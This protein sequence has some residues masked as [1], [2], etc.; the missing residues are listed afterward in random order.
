ML[1]SARIYQKLHINVFFCIQTIKSQMHKW[2]GFVTFILGSCCVKCWLLHSNASFHQW[3]LTCLYVT[4]YP[5][6]VCKDFLPLFELS[7]TQLFFYVLR[8][9]CVSVYNNTLFDIRCRNFE[10]L[11]QGDELL[12]QICA[13]IMIFQSL[14]I[15]RKAGIINPNIPSRLIHPYQLGESI[16]RFRDV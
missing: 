15:F 11:N 2:C 7:K 6:Y 3:N 9:F 13:T 12:S 16:S 10:R 5:N 8:L 14:M 1:H 4:D